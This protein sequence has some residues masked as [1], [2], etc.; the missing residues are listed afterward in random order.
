MALINFTSQLDAADSVMDLARRLGKICLDE[1]GELGRML[2]DEQTN[3]EVKRMEL[4]VA[5]VPR[6]AWEEVIANPSALEE[7]A[8]STLVALIDR[9][10]MRQPLDFL[11]VLRGLCRKALPEHYRITNDQVG[12]D[13]GMPI[14]FATRPV[15]R[16]FECTTSQETLNRA[17]LLAPLPYSLFP[18]SAKG[19]V[20]VVLDF[21]HGARID[22]LTWKG[23]AG[24]PRI[25]TIHPEGGG[26]VAVNTIDS[27]HFFDVQ[28]ARWDADAVMELLACASDVE[29]AVLPELSLPSPGELEKKLAENAGK[30]PPIVVAGSAHSRTTVAGNSHEIRSNESRVY[31]DG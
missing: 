2:L 17:S 8:G 28:P 3:V 7:R 24:L 11:G 29:I 21:S 27:A 26:E 5:Q 4:M 6:T 1:G 12:L 25:A 16:Q 14:P 30:C 19:Q 23:D 13:E 18:F 15:H 10:Q 20:R 9:A 31:L 22:E